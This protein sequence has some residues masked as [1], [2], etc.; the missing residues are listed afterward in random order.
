LRS[1]NRYPSLQLARLVIERLPAIF[2]VIG[3]ILNLPQFN[4]HSE[5]GYHGLGGVFDEQESVHDI[6][7]GI[8]AGSDSSGG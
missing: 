1:M 4:G 7:K 8:Q 5:K 2:L 3:G 6:Y